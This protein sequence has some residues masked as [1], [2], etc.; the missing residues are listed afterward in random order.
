VSGDDLRARAR[1][2]SES[3]P[4]PPEWGEGVELEEGSGEFYGRYRGIGTDPAFKSPAVLLWDEAGE[5]LF[6]WT[7]ARLDRELERE[8]PEIGADI[9]I[10]R[11]PNYLT[12]YDRAEGRDPT[13]LGYGVATA[14]NPAPLPAAD[15][16]SADDIPF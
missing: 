7:C 1:E 5:K 14:P 9:A 2:N 10:Y 16:D 6:I 15:D 3:T 4:V 12:Q 13:G 11:G 8:R